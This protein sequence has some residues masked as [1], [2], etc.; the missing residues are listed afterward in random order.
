MTAEKGK[1]REIRE[2]LIIIAPDRSA[3]CFGCMEMECKSK[4]GVLNAE[5][6]KALPLKIGQTVEI[7][8]QGASFLSILKQ[9]IGALLPPALGFIAGFYFTRLF[10]PDIKEE[11]AVF[12]GVIQLFVTAFIVYKIRKKFPAKEYPRYV[13]R[14]VG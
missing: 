10:F 8:I 1:I 9:S 3:S 7:K 5:N 4:G 11:A 14:I 6:P 13:E 12:I 2:N